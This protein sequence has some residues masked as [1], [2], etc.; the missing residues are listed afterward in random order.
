MLT[1]H[2]DDSYLYQ[3]KI[4]A[5]FST[6]VWYGGEP[7]GLKEHLF[8]HWSIITKYPEVAAESLSKKVSEQHGFSPENVIT[9]NGT[10]ESIYLIAQAYKYNTTTIV[11]PSFSEYE[12]A[13]S[14]YDHAIDFLYWQQLNTATVIQTNLCFICNPNNPTGDVFYDLYKLIE[15]NPKTIFIVD[16]AFI[17]FTCSIQSVIGLIKTHQ[18]LVVLRSMTKAFAIPGLRLGYIAAHSS[19]IGKL[20]SLK[21]PWSVNALAIEA[22]KFIF[23][24]YNSLQIPLLELLKQKEDFMNDLQQLSI[25]VHP[26]HTHFFLAETTQKTALELK[27]YLLDNFAILIRNADNF[28]GLSNRHFRIATLTPNKNQLLV[29]ALKEW[30]ING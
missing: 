10:T 20:R 9:S 14:I 11:I 27:Q 17:E 24:H 26:G 2:G 21:L 6:N 18:N 19:I 13:C 28:R 8:D 15:R 7:K 16:E 30:K 29:N 5:D 22:G 3:Q 12:D 23:D 25:R 1:G 4:V